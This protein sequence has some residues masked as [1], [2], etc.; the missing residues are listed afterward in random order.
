MGEEAR[1]SK[2]SSSVCESLPELGVGTREMLRRLSLKL[3]V[4]S[5]DNRGKIVDGDVSARVRDSSKGR[6]IVVWLRTDGREEGDMGGRGYIKGRG[7]SGRSSATLKRTGSQTKEDGMRMWLARRGRTMGRKRDVLCADSV[8]AV[9]SDRSCQCRVGRAER[10][11]ERED[12]GWGHDM[13]GRGGGQKHMLNNS[14]IVNVGDLVHGVITTERCRCRGGA[15]QQGRERRQERDQDRASIWEEGIVDRQPHLFSNVFRP[16]DPP[17]PP[18]P[19]SAHPAPSPTAAASPQVPE[20]QVLFL[21]IQPYSSCL[22]LAPAS[23]RS[24]GNISHNGSSLARKEC[25]L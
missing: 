20:D 4:V 15:K 24:P 2:I 6:G 1:V 23:A 17:S 3:L 14:I 5:M 19:P 8:T 11:A 10:T 21:P 9:E 18:S 13:R 22:A 7:G 25:K 12:E 16:L